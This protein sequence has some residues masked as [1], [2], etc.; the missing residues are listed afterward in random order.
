MHGV[1][2]RERKCKNLLYSGQ[3]KRETA[4]KT[5]YAVKGRKKNS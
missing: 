2:A 3:Q 4:D 5:Q 1:I